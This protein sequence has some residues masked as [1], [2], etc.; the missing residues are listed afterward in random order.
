MVCFIKCYSISWKCIFKWCCTFLTITLILHIWR[1]LRLLVVLA[2]REILNHVFH[3]FGV[4]KSRILQ[5]HRQKEWRMIK[6]TYSEKTK[7]DFLKEFDVFCYECQC[8]SGTYTLVLMGMPELESTSL[9][10][11]CWSSG[12]DSIVLVGFCSVVWW[13]D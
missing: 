10:N 13:V 5:P 2:L 8:K 9:V 7:I 1:E 4:M 11:A 3:T 12:M 6:I